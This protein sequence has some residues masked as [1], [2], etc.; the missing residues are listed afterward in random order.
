MPEQRKARHDKTRARQS[1]GCT[2]LPIPP[3]VC[4]TMINYKHGVAIRQ[5]MDK[6]SKRRKN[7]KM[8]EK[9]GT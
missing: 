6:R 4:D 3:T 5:R 2:E 9:Y 8:P 7:R 1:S